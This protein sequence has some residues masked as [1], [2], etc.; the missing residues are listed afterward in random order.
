MNWTERG[1]IALRMDQVAQ[2]RE[3]TDIV[4]L[5]SEYLPLKKLG[6]NF[7][8]TCPFHNEKSPSFV[9]SP[10]RQIWHCFGCQKG[11]DVFTFLMEYEN[12]EFPEALRLL[13]K[14]V[15]IEL[16]QYKGSLGTTSKKEQL[17]KV[18]KLAMEFYHYIL[19]SH[20][21]G[22]KALEY[23]LHE[24][25]INREVINTF[26]LGFAPAKGWALVDYLL[27][28]KKFQK[29]DVIDAGLTSMRGGRVSDFFTDRLLF[30]LF[31][32]RDN[33]I[34]FSGRV[35][36]PSTTTMGKYINTRETLI[37]HKGDVFFGLHITKNEIKK[38]NR[39]IIMEGEFDVISSFQE[40][41]GNAVAVK[42]TAL[43][44]SQVN[45]L[46]RFCSKVSL[47]FDQD[48]AGQQAL[49]R[50]IPT[51]EKKGL[52]I[53]VVLTPGGKDP[54]DSLIVDPFVFK[55]AVKHDIGVYDYLIDQ[56]VKKYAGESVDDKKQ[57]SDTILPFLHGIEN[58]IIKEHYMRLLATKLDTSYESIERQIEKSRTQQVAEKVVQA[59][60]EKKPREEMLEEYLLALVL[61]SPS[62]KLAVGKVAD[63]MESFIPKER[64]Y[65]KILYHLLTHFQKHEEINIKQFVDGLSPELV[66]TYD[67]CFLYP[68]PKFSDDTVYLEE[69]E[70]VATELKMQYIRLSMK[71]IA[72]T[73][74]E[75]ESKGEATEELQEEFTRLSA[76][77]HKSS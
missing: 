63:V 26:Q 43:T 30:P 69:I 70:K 53:T 38:E 58:E 7:K 48:S 9:V 14:K 51:L 66:T 44:V 34:G 29:E 8:T 52:T 46:A 31:D 74:Q 18:N 17:Y 36:D 62:P 55:Q 13:A 19:T 76:Q 77:M 41:I 42:G 6:R 39:A 67:T 75:K 12:L 72:T 35:L 60:Q 49:Q 40:G 5:L 37:Y 54:H 59:V 68:L 27:T 24:R 33:V 28:K 50:S 10:E 1:T 3:K 47:C 65:Q 20:P 45:L 61:Q 22:K 11:G 25:H 21:A 4:S 71:A 56:T 23:L 2:V 57:I 16:E 32:H 15:G 73:M 64:A